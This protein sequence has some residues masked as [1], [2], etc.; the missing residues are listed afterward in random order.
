MVT[1]YAEPATA[2]DGRVNGP[3]LKGDLVVDDN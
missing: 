3:P 1:T 2:A